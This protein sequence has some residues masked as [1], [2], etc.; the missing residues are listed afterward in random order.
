MLCPPRLKKWGDTSPVSP[1]KLR[2]WFVNAKTL[3]MFMLFSEQARRRPTWCVR[4]TWRPP[5]PRWRH[6]A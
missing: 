5:T 6:L 3:I 1:T 4:A 2:P